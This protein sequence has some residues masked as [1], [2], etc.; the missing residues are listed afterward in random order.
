MAASALTRRLF[1]ALALGSERL[2]LRAVPISCERGA[3]ARADVKHAP[4]SRTA[5]DARK[6]ALLYIVM[7]S[8]EGCGLRE[9]EPDIF[10][11]RTENCARLAQG[12]RRRSRVR[13]LRRLQGPCR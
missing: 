7:C 5:R 13:L 12:C 11:C 9:R 6:G 2:C 10:P 3:D 4:T 1:R 8:K